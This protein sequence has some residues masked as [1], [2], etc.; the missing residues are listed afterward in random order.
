MPKKIYRGIPEREVTDEKTYLARRILLKSLGLGAL[1]YFTS[2]LL[3]N[4]EGLGKK[5]WMAEKFRLINKSDVSDLFNPT[6][7]KYVTSYT[8]THI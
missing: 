2:N 4:S 1:G 5:D 7:F 3:A 6:P 8:C